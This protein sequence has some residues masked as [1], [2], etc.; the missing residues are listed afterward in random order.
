MTSLNSEMPWVE[1]GVRPVLLTC[2]T[3]QSFKNVW[4]FSTFNSD[5]IEPQNHIPCLYVSNF[6]FNLLGIIHRRRPV[7][8]CIMVINMI[9][10]GEEPV[11]KLALK[12]EPNYTKQSTTQLCQH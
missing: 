3:F 8:A 1:L 6:F 5:P 10:G 7:P 4:K 9:L 2:W 11:S 12:L